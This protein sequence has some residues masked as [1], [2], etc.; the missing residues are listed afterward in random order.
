[1]HRICQQGHG[2]G[3]DA[4]ADLRRDKDRIKPDA[5]SE[6]GIVACWPVMMVAV[7]AAMPMCSRGSVLAPIRPMIVVLMIAGVMRMVMWHAVAPFDVPC[8]LL[9]SRPV[10]FQDINA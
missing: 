10:F 2:A 6:R 9:T 5:D 8:H 7:S 1:V 4:D 3:G